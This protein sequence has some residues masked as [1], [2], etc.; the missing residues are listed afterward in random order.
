MSDQN[1]A[2]KLPTQ[3]TEIEENASGVIA[4][5]IENNLNLSSGAIM[6]LFTL[7]TLIILD[8]L[9]GL[10]CGKVVIWDIISGYFWAYT[11]VYFGVLGFFVGTKIHNKRMEAKENIAKI[12]NNNNNSII[13]K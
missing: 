4:T 3:T 9:W 11:S 7:Q 13:P 2:I 12:Q 8:V 6:G 5:W 10:L 1:D